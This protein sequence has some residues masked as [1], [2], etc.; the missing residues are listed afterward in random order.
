M[1]SGVASAEAR[2][3]N[4]VVLQVYEV[5]TSG[6]TVRVHE[7]RVHKLRAHELV[8]RVHELFIQVYQL[9]VHELRVHGLPISGDSFR[10]IIEDPYN[11]AV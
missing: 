11:H 9:R 7:L 4:N 8:I 1:A 3:V 2:S 6:H 10:K 5:V